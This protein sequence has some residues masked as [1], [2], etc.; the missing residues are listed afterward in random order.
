MHEKKMI[1]PV[2]IESFYDALADDYDSMTRFDTRLERE[3]ETM[4]RLVDTY[5]ISSA[6]D[7]G[8]GTGFHSIL[9]AK[10]GVDVTAVDVS[11]EM[12]SR[13]ETNAERFGVSVQIVVSD[14][15]SLPKAI[16]RTYDA[17]FCL[18]NSIAHTDTDSLPA[19]SLE[20]FHSLL[21]YGGTLVLQLLNYERILS[22]RN[23][24]QNI[25]E[26]NGKTFI[27]YYEYH[28]NR[29]IFNIVT[30]RKSGTGID[31]SVQSVPL[32]PIRRNQLVSALADAGFTDI[33][34]YGNLQLDAYDHKKSANLVA[35]C[36]K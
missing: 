13:L 1:S 11:R 36:R 29:I 16:D 10:L 18:G 3:H 14:F 7:A 35:V 27:R 20:G 30:F 15:A 22:E 23:K 34:T 21:H 19:D 31:Y 17:V 4:K 32:Y 8:A 24:I 6:I 9:L 33:R 25:R 26:E 12:L 28:T 2:E 5:S